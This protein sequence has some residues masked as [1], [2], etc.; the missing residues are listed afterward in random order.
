[1]RKDDTKRDKKTGGQRERP[2]RWINWVIRLELSQIRLESYAWCWLQI[3]FLCL[4]SVSSLSPYSSL[5]AEKSMNPKECMGSPFKCNCTL[6]SHC[7]RDWGG[8]EASIFTA[9]Q[10]LP[11]QISFTDN[12]RNRERHFFDCLMLNIPPGGRGGHAL[13]TASHIP[14]WD[15]G[16]TVRAHWDAGWWHV[17]KAENPVHTWAAWALQTLVLI[18]KIYRSEWAMERKF[19]LGAHGLA[20]RWREFRSWC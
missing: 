6:E 2:Q 11:D 15:R 12:P 7:K 16:A 10:S 13:S 9:S 1:M 14:E 18:T 4:R 8:G 5:G 19:V 20:L 3:P 17:C